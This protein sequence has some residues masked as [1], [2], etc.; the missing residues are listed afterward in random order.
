MNPTSAD[1]AN[2]RFRDEQ[3]NL[4]PFEQLYDRYFD[5][6][7][8]H[9]L[10]RVGSAADAEDLT[11]Q[12][13]FKALKNHWRF[14]WQ[15]VPVLAWLYRIAGNETNSFLRKNKRRVL[16]DGARFDETQTGGTNPADQELISAERELAKFQAFGAI[17]E[18]I[19]KLK[20][21]DQTLIVLRF[22]EQKSFKEIADITGKRVGAVTMRT[23][24]A[25]NA[26]RAHLEERGIDHERLRENTERAGQTQTSGSVLQARLAARTH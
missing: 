18:S 14:R 15:G 11:A 5:T 24:R 26:L 9:I 17:Q 23:H 3:G 12:T 7:F 1:A 10:Y 20:P 2:V 6:I 21:I 16:T 25:L 4:V 19:T 8:H 13:F 22:L